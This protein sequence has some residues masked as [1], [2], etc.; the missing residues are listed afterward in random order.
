M[1]EHVLINLYLLQV[2]SSK[3]AILWGQILSKPRLAGFAAFLLTKLV[4][5]PKNR[6]DLSSAATREA[7][8]NTFTAPSHK[9]LNWVLTIQSN[10]CAILLFI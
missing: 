8:I 10:S 3:V 4:Y 7:N 5:E 1:E 9:H 6:R 2:L